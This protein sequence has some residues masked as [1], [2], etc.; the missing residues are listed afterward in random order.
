MTNTTQNILNNYSSITNYYS[1][2]SDREKAFAAWKKENPSSN[3][4]LETWIKE[5]AASCRGT[6][7]SWGR[8]ICQQREDL[9]NRHKG[10]VDELFHKYA[11]RIDLKTGDV[12]LDCSPKKMWLKSLAHT[13]WRIEYTVIQVFL[14]LAGLLFVR[15]YEL[16][17]GGSIE[18]FLSHEWEHLKNLIRM[19]L[20]GATQTVITLVSTILFPIVS[21]FSEAAAA[22]LIFTCSKH[23]G[24]LELHM[25]RGKNH[26]IVRRNSSTSKQPR[27]LG[28][29]WHRVR[30]WENLVK[31]F[32][33]MGNIMTETGQISKNEKDRGCYAL[34]L[35][36]I[37]EWQQDPTC[38][39]CCVDFGH[40]IPYVSP[41][42]K[43]S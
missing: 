19:P 1:G 29:L 42:I 37:G 28:Y 10:G 32:M 25:H 15:P 31:C 9:V 24:N 3:K 35:K 40:Q 18:K 17:K 6:S 22:D 33:P 14:E 8:I 4:A 13:A 26:A 30:Y 5:G 23:V 41:C 2:F 36:V 7:N 21:L 20:Y 38:W 11:P 43:K 12:Y 27:A 34:A 16:L 39:N